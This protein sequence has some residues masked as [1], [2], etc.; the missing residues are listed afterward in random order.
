MR[1]RIVLTVV[2]TLLIT[3]AGCGEAAPTK[4]IALNEKRAQKAI[5]ERLDRHAKELGWVGQWKVNVVGVEGGDHV[6]NG[7]GRA[8][9]YLNVEDIPYKVEGKAN[10]EGYSGRATAEFGKGEKSPWTLYRIESWDDRRIRIDG[11]GLEITP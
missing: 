8:T 3:L 4:P 7:V 11:G 10:V 5:E 9:A 1:N 2:Y 6:G